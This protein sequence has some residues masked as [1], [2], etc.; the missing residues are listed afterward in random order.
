M[1]AREP[2]EQEDATM[3]M[4]LLFYLS[5]G[6][7]GCGAG[8][9][10]VSVNGEHEAQEATVGSP[11]IP[12]PVA[13]GTV[14]EADTQGTKVEEE[15]AI[16]P[17]AAPAPAP[18]GPLEATETESLLQIRI[19]SDKGEV[20]PGIMVTVDNAGGQRFVSRESDENGFLE[21]LVPR[22]D[23]YYL[24]FVSLQEDE[25]KMEIAMPDKPFITAQYELT[26]TP[27][28]TRSFV[29]KGVFFDTAKWTLRPESYPN[30]EHLLEFM[31]LK[32]S[33]VIRLEGHTD[34]VG[35]DQ[36]NQVLSQKRAEAVRRYLIKK[37]I[38]PNRIEAVGYGESKPVAT[39]D[40][41]EGRQT[42]RRTV[43]TIL[44]E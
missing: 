38:S 23:T 27:A 16:E 15:T 9:A 3:R 41:E 34:S 4:P 13:G 33:A 37:G 21:L 32:K 14:S 5:I 6:L 19:V 1:R 22:G 43:V 36:A 12:A 31:T 26:H 2:G 39:N 7:T 25:V 29:L 18:E 28:V 40:T 30:L 35:N 44:S 8:Q 11:P 17:A 42:N 10:E 24:G 20:I